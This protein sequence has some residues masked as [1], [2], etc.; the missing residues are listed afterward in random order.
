MDRFYLLVIAGEQTGILDD[1]LSV[2]LNREDANGGCH[3]LGTNYASAD[4]A[5]IGL[6]AMQRANSTLEDFVSN[7][8]ILY[9]MS[10]DHNG[11]SRQSSVF[12]E[13]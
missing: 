9:C 2:D 1:S 8:S 7:F 11:L 10:L 4:V 3:G 13:F 5:L 12:W 6:D